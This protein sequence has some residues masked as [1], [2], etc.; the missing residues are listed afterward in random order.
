MSLPLDGQNALVTG[1]SRG[2]GRQVAETLARAG[3]RVVLTARSAAGA[4]SAAQEI[5]AAGFQAH[6]IELD[7]TSDDS[8]RRALASLA[9]DY[10]RI[11]ILVNNAGITSDNLLLRMKVEDWD[12]V[13]Q[14]NLAGV[15]RLCR[16][17][18][19]SMVRARLG[20]IVNITSVVATTGNP[21]QTNYAAAKAGTEGFSRSLARELA[22]RNVT[23]NCVAPGFIDTD[24]TR[25]LGEAARAKLLDQ[26]P[27]QRL[28]TAEDVAQ[29]VLYLVGPGAPY[30]T[31]ITL[32]VNGGMYM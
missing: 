9:D 21:G 7:V 23:V 5:A 10:A 15:Y 26:I 1:G 3:A 8:V 13:L 30:V 32:H 27:M 2:I 25:E 19:P 22:S 6:G 14:T 12:R 4:E 17:L 28:G 31:G 11:P 18:V 20:R 16:A 29:A 24:M